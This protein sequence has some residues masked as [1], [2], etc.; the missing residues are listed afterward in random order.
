[1]EEVKP[2]TLR[3]SSKGWVPFGL[4][5]WSTGLS[6]NPLISS[7]IELKKDKRTRSLVTDRKLRVIDDETGKSHA[8]VWAVGDA[9]VF[10]DEPLPAT[11]QVASQKAPYLVKGLNKGELTDDFKFQFRGSLAYVGDWKAIYDRSGAESGPQTK[12]TGRVAWLLWRSAYFSM[13]MSP[14]NMLNIPWYWFTNWIIG[15]DLGR[16]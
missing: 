9:S 13:A 2:L 11:A 12:A 4:C 15:R 7:L 3:V 1:V 14:R 16:F 8:H 6:A 10:E 5:V